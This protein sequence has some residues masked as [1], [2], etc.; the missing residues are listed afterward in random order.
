[1]GAVSRRAWLPSAL[2]FRLSSDLFIF[3]ARV[4]QGVG[5][6][7]HQI[8]PDEQRR[9]EQRKAHDEGVIAVQRA[10][11]QKNANAGYL[12]NVLDDKRAGQQVGQ[13]RAG[14]G[15]TGSTAMRQAC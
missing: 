9:V 15:T 1:M 11:D 6:I 5:E 14:I 2:G 7:H 12:E 8:Q 3:H 10:V 4:E 13:H